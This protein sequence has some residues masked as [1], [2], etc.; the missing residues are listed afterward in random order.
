M[1]G[2]NYEIFTQGCFN[3]INR[4]CVFHL[5]L[6]K[7]IILWSLYTLTFTWF[8]IFLK[9]TYLYMVDVFFFVI[10]YYP[11]ICYKNYILKLICAPNIVM[12]NF[13]HIV[14]HFFFIYLFFTLC[15][16]SSKFCHHGLDFEII[17]LFI[18]IKKINL[19]IS[20]YLK[21]YYKTHFTRKTN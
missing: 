12:E 1:Y 19:K 3:H 11:K 7:L 20:K 21:H 13:Q 6:F 2:E 4:I 15:I 18:F 14:D 9:P 16:K 5:P 8:G 17:N 10:F